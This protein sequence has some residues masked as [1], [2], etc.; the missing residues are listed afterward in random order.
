M[1]ILG[2]FQFDCVGIYMLYRHTFE[3]V[4]GETDQYCAKR[5]KIL[6]QGNNEFNT[7]DLKK[8]CINSITFIHYLTMI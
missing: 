2:L 8:S 3:C 6:A 7:I 1:V 4:P 5:V